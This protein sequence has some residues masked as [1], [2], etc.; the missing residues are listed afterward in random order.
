MSGVVRGCHH[1][2]DFLVVF[3]PSNGSELSLFL[4]VVFLFLR[5][6]FFCFCVFVHLGYYRPS[7]G[8]PCLPPEVQK[9]FIISA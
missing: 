6:N 2:V 1:V 5:W 7:P 8:F 4:R 9:H 3:Q